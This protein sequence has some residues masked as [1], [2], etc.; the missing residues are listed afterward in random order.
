MNTMC[1]ETGKLWLVKLDVLYCSLWPA[2]AIYFPSQNMECLNGNEL[3]VHSRGWK[4]V[5][6]RGGVGKGGVGRHKGRG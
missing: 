1:S 2:Q 3:A 4:G 5:D 6:R